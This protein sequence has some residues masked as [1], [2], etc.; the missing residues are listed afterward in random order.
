[1]TNQT[2]PSQSPLMILCLR[3]NGLDCCG[4]F[5]GLGHNLSVLSS[6]Q[7]TSKVPPIM[8]PFPIAG[9]TQT[10]VRGLFPMVAN[11]KSPSASLGLFAASGDDS[12][13]RILWA[14]AV[15]I[16]Q[17]DVEEKS[18]Q[19]NLMGEIYGRASR[20]LIWLG[21]DPDGDA[22]EALRFIK[23]INRHLEREVLNIS[24]KQESLSQKPISTKFHD[25]PALA[26]NSP[27]LSIA[28]WQIFKTLRS[29]PFF[30][31]VW[32][33]QEVGLMRQ[34]SLAKLSQRVFSRVSIPT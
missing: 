9:G 24:A 1:M 7:S 12:L 33:L 11:S 19:V 30:S 22:E 5:R 26:S 17:S 16:D 27:L 34:Y 15:C 6:S 28:S 4:C 31:R 29:H 20:V 3:E 32:V 21:E 8:K 10:I 2:T 23:D 18:H 13:P 14:D 25:I